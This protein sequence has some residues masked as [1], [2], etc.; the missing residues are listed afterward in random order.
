MSFYCALILYIQDLNY[1]NKPISN[2]MGSEK[3]FPF[4][5]FSI[6]SYNYLDNGENQN[7]QIVIYL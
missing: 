6:N 7:T 2:D 3:F 1:K 5:M 4:L